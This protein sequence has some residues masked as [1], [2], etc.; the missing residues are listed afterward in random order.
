[1]IV[2][3]HIEYIIS[4]ISVDYLDLISRSQ[5]HIVLG[6]PSIPGTPSP[7]F[8]E[9]WSETSE[10]EDSSSYTR[11]HGR[12]SLWSERIA[13]TIYGGYD[14]AIALS[15]ASINLVLQSRHTAV[16]SWKKDKFFSMELRPLT[17]RLLSNGKAIV[18][19]QAEGKI[20]V[21]KCAVQC[22]I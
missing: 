2:L 1:M 4:F 5:L 12:L 17:I 19:V 16:T 9:S 21:K 20:G 22:F 14:Q 18:Y 10:G 11:Q 13:T 15:E 7:Y 3:E 8:D 6:F